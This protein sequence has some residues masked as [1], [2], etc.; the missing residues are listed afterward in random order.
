MATQKPLDTVHIFNSEEQ[1]N[2]NKASVGDDDIAFVK[3]GNTFDYIVETYNDGTNWY[4][5]W[6]SGWLEQG[7]TVPI[8]TS[9]L[10]SNF[11]KAFINPPVFLSFYRVTTRGA[12]SYDNELYPQSVTNTG[13]SSKANVTGLT[14]YRYYACGF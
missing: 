1:F 10:T 13:F 3:L 11:V 6:A 12:S 2:A 5:K 7:G 4:R 8:N 9:L 14:S